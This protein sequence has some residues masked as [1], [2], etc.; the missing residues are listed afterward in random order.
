MLT[1]LMDT[2]SFYKN[3]DSFRE[4]NEFTTESHFKPLPDDWTILITD[5][6]G[7]TKAVAAG[8]Y[9]EVNTVGAATIVVARKGMGEAD[10]PFVFGGDGATLLIPNKY[11]D[12]VLENLAALQKLSQTN[13]NLDLRIGLVSMKEL[14]QAKQEV[15]VGKFEITPG[16]SIAILRG[17]GISYAEKLIKDESGKYLSKIETEKSPDLSGLSCRWNPIPSKKGKIFTILVSSKSDNTIY[18]SFLTEL[19]KILPQGIEESNPTN[20][21][22]ASYKS[23]GKLIAEERK[24]HPSLLSLS[25]LKRALEICYAVL[26]FKYHFPALIFDAKKYSQS[27]RSHSDFRKFDDVLRMVLDCS[28]EQIQAIKTYLEKKY[29]AGDLF[30]GTFE[31]DCSLMTCFVDGL[32]QGEHIHFID[33]ENGGYTAAAIMMKKQMKQDQI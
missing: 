9:K 3:L 33:A 1:S 27:M 26:V 7:S 2:Q 23:V 11:L 24:L 19:N 31:T 22:L 12:S 10:F 16:R 28:L 8:K 25:F 32:G 30:Y 20:V 13:Q 15:F 14:T 4:F 21:D 29:A 6:K 5:I 18:K 17:K